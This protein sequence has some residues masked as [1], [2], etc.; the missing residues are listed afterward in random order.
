[1]PTAVSSGI[2]WLWQVVELEQRLASALESLSAAEKRL[3]DADVRTAATLRWEFAARPAA[4][5]CSAR[6]R[7][8]VGERSLRF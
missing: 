1:V 4:A 3:R 5:A 8:L 7:V 2:D 6:A